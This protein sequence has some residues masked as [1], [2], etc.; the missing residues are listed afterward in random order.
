M[1]SE[2]EVSRRLVY[3]E[4][5]KSDVTG[6]ADWFEDASIGLGLEFTEAVAQAIESLERQPLIYSILYDQYRRVLITRFRV[7]IPYLID[8]DSIYVAGVVHATRD[9]EAWLQSRLSGG[10][11]E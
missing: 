5:F 8:G 1:A 7:I 3:H 10:F 4:M 2:P 11:G 6:Y 9:L